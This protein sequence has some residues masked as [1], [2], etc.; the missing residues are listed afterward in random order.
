MSCSPRRA[1]RSIAALVIALSGTALSAHAADI[2][3]PAPAQGPSPSFTPLIADGP[4]DLYHQEQV[5]VRFE[6]SATPAQIAAAH[7]AAGAMKTVWSYHLV[8]GLSCMQVPLGGVEAAVAAYR[9]SPGVRYA[10]FDLWRHAM[11]QTTPYGIPMVGAPVVWS[12]GLGAGNR[13]AGARIAVLDTGI[14]LT[15]EDL[16]VP[17]L[18][19][20]FINGQTVDDFNDHGTHVSGTVLAIDNDLGVIGV[21]PEASLMIGKVLSNGGSGPTSGVMAGAQWASDN[22]A[23]VISMSLGGGGESQAESDLYAAIVANDVLVVAAAGNANSDVPSFPGSYP[24]NVCVAAVDSSQNRANFSNFGVTV[25]ITGPGVGVLSTIPDL[26]IA[27]VAQVTWEDAPRS[28]NALT[29]SGTGTVVAQTIFC[30]IGNPAEFPPSVAGNIAHIRRRG[31]SA[32]TG[33]TMTFREKADNAIAAGAVAVIIS[34]NAGGLFTG[35]LNNNYTIPIVGI[36]Q[37]DGDALEAISGVLATVRN[38]SEQVIRTNP[39]ASFSGTSMSTPHVAGV[40]GLL[41]GL[42]GPENITVAQLRDALEST[43][44]DLGDP[45]RDDLFGH[46]LVRAD[47]AKTYLDTIIVI[48]PGCPADFNGDGNTDPDDLSDYI[49]CYFAQPPCAAAD[50][51]GD[52][53]TDPDDLSDYISA[54]FGGCP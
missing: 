44:Q 43:A 12:T 2:A 26:T 18:H 6:A 36:S 24:S 17:V 42:Y 8:P 23:H 14:D 33:E 39:Y 37:S 38:T 15:H 40:A 32:A 29:G 3:Q 34:N 5:L 25:D 53:N 28:A 45:G 20:S 41:I 11:A 16:P 10:E 52:G 47:L 9:A 27:N 19:E 35:T 46:G 30:G 1:S 54:F 50:F 49:A 7:T 4:A 21:A 48:T 51:S 31:T 13:G 22:G